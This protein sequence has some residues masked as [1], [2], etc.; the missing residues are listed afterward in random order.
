MGLNWTEDKITCICAKDQNGKRFGMAGPN[1][2][3]IIDGFLDWMTDNFSSDTHKLVTYNGKNFDIQFII[4]RFI[5]SYQQEKLVTFLLDYNH[6][7]IFEFIRKL[8][9]KRIG[10]DT[11]SKLLGC[12]SLK[13]GSGVGAI[14]LAKQ[15]KWKELKEYCAGDVDTTEELYLKIKQIHEV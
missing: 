2:I 15:K 5:L 11:V 13:T 9:K 3:K 4:G 6:F 14:D 8:T 7:D 10:L 1:E 12:K